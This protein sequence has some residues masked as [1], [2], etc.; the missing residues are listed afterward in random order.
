[1]VPLIIQRDRVAVE[2][3]PLKKEKYFVSKDMM[4]MQL[5]F[6]IIKSAG[7]MSKE[8]GLFLFFGNSKSKRLEHLG[9]GLHHSESKLSDIYNK[10]RDQ[11]GFL[12]VTYT[13]VS[14]F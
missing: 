5:K 4:I 9:R 14:L 3:P 8:Q 10:Y 12:Y 7:T 13:N 6:M 11:D 2:L 1:M